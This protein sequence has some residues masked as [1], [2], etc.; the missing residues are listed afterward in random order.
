MNKRLILWATLCIGAAC[1]EQIEG[2]QYYPEGPCDGL[3]CTVT[4]DDEDC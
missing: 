4:C 3:D 2:S 1:S